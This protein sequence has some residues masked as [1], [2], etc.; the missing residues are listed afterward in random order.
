MEITKTR[1]QDPAQRPV[2][3]RVLA[4]TL[5]TLLRLLHPFTPFLTEEIWQTLA[6]LAPKRGLTPV[7]AAASVMIAAWPL[8]EESRIHPTIETQF[9]TFQ[10]VLASLRNVRA[11][12][13]I[14]TRE[15]LAFVVRCDA[16]LGELMRPMTEVFVAMAGATPVA[17]GPNVEI[18]K[19][20]DHTMLPG[21]EIF[22]DLTGHIDVATELAKK[23]DELA[24]VEGRIAGQQKK[25]SN[26]NFVKRAPA[27]VIE[28]ERTTLAELQTQVT[29]IRDAIV[30]LET[31]GTPS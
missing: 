25:L 4:H 3:Q 26:E 20:A 12:Q 22:V 11:T 10:S 24:K 9:A 1:L 30:R 29:A 8:V 2:A 28:K 27:A 31:L 6:K 7:D 14:G 15:N 13:N 23:R 17:W 18:P 21:M 19:L 16:A 5:D